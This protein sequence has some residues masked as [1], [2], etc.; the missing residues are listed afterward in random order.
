MA[1]PTSPALLAMVQP[2]AAGQSDA[3]LLAWFAM[4]PDAIEALSVA[5]REHAL[6]I[7]AGKIPLTTEQRRKR[8]SMTLERAIEGA[9]ADYLRD[10]MANGDR[11][12]AGEPVAAEPARAFDRVADIIAAGVRSGAVTHVSIDVG[13]D[14]EVDERAEQLRLA[15]ATVWN[16]G[17]ATVVPG[18]HW[19]QAGADIEN[20]SGGWLR[21]TISSPHVEVCDLARSS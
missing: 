8:H 9:A 16:I 20:Q 6:G 5:E 19:R 3:E 4:N 15:G 1:P 12:Q 11:V 7:L 18:K 13:S 14:A 10:R 21:I 2:I 17:D